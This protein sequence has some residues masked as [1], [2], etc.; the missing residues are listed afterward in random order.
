MKK[1]YSYFRKSLK[2]FF[3]EQDLE[4]NRIQEIYESLDSVNV[5]YKKAIQA[6]IKKNKKIKDKLFT[7]RQSLALNWRNDDEDKVDELMKYF[8][9]SSQESHLLKLKSVMEKFNNALEMI[10]PKHILL[11][12]ENK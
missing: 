8:D 2:A 4:I 10:F 5:M 3:I 12:K 11:N 7:I 6:D 1:E 9:I